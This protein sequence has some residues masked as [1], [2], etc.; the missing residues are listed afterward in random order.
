MLGYALELYTTLGEADLTTHRVPADG[1][2]T[3]ETINGMSVVDVD[4]EENRELLEE[5]LG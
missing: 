5:I 2:Y 1:T 4:F 3:Y